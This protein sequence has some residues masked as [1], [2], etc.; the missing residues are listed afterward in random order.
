MAFIV[1]E[2]GTHEVR[3]LGSGPLPKL[4]PAVQLARRGW[5]CIVPLHVIESTVA[6]G[7]QCDEQREKPNHRAAQDWAHKQHAT[8]PNSHHY[9]CFLNREVG[10]G[11]TFCKEGWA[12]ISGSQDHGTINH[13]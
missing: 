10:R 8:H 11:L 12:N 5:G 1:P 6:A 3:Q 2:S 4:F 7:S 9:F 13:F